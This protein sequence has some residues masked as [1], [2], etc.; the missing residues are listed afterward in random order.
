MTGSAWVM[1]GVTWSV[2]IFFTAK[3]FLKVLRTPPKE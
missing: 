3:F 2:V 1:L